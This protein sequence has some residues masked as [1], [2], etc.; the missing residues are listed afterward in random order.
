MNESEQKAIVTLCILAAFADGAQSEVE[1]TQIQKILQGFSN[2]ALDLTA[3]YQEALVGKVTLTEVASR[4]QSPASKMLAYE[5]TVCVCHADGVLTE[6]ERQF[7]TQLRDA[8]QLDAQSTAGIHQ[9]A[10]AIAVEPLADAAS[11]ANATV[12]EAELDKM[13]LNYAILNGALE[14]MPHSLATMAI[15][16]LQMRMVYRVGKSYGF[17]LGRGH[18][19]DF[20]ATLGIGLTSQVFEGLTSRLFGGLVRPL[21]GRFLGGLMGQAAGS[22]FGFVTTYALGKVA[23]KYYAGGRTLTTSELKEVFASM[24]EEARGVQGRYAGEMA[25]K[26]REVRVTDLVPLM[27]QS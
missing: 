21:A 2:E 13:I 8:L 7:L 12:R 6:P 26:S 25:Q 19:R 17:E 24:L 3:A 18:I 27:K 15:V 9:D 5:M 22:A 4:L 14:I 23:R 11:G 16:P 20:L 10:S 1:R